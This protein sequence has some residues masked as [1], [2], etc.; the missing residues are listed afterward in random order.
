MR[1]NK[2]QIQVF[3]ISFLDVIT[4][5]LGAIIILFVV[6]PKAT[7][8]PE[9]KTT[10]IQRMHSI[11]Q[12]LK[13][14]NKVLSQENSNLNKEINQK[15]VEKPKVNKNPTLFGLPTKLGNTVFLIDVSGSMAWQE[16]R[17]FRTLESLVMG[18]E[19]S[20]FRFIYFDELVYSSGKYWPHDWLNGSQTNKLNALRDAKIFLSK[21]IIEE[22]G[23]T[24][25]S[26]ALYEA[27][28]IKETEA[29]FF[30]TDGYPTVGETDI[31]K[32]LN[33]VK[34]LNKKRAIINSVMV[35]LP[36]A[37]TNQYGK[38]VFVESARPKELYDFLHELAEDNDGVYIGR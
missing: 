32:I 37:T 13:S 17:L 1:L 12:S 7:P 34:W 30:I 29:I 8:S 2:G 19:L 25:S 5:A 35:G 28:T 9:A 18:C 26:D 15:K 20:S 22:P 36:G 33:R 31:N 4:C 11:I 21:L 24:N 23:G 10:V 16:D 27:I 6:V 3:S 38:V 14:E